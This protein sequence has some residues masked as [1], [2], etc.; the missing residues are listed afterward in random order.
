MRTI[1][2]K[3]ARIERASTLSIQEGFVTNET[4]ASMKS[5]GV[6]QIAIKSNEVVR[7][8]QDNDLGTDRHARIEISHM[9]V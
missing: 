4:A 6:Y 7:S 9:G 3:V 5:G 2:K 8:L 1:R